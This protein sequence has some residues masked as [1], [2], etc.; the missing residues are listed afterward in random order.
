MRKTLRLLL[1]SSLIAALALSPLA[2]ASGVGYSELVS[3]CG[4]RAQRSCND[5]FG[6]GCTASKC[7]D[8]IADVIAGKKSQVEYEKHCENDCSGQLSAYAQLKEKWLRHLQTYNPCTDDFP[9]L[10]EP[11]SPEGC[12]SS[13]FVTYEELLQLRCQIVSKRQ[14][15][16]C[17][18]PPA[19]PVPETDF[20]L[21]AY[22]ERRFCWYE[23]E[24][25][26]SAYECRQQSAG[27]PGMGASCAASAAEAARESGC[28]L[29]PSLNSVALKQ[30]IKTRTNDDAARVL[31]IEP[32]RPTDSF[33][34]LDQIA[35]DIHGGTFRTHRTRQW[36]TLPQSVNPGAQVRDETGVF[37]WYEA[38]GNYF[39]QVIS[40][41]GTT[42][43]IEAVE[44][45]NPSLL[46]ASDQCGTTE[47]RELLNHDWR[48]IERMLSQ[49]A[50][51]WLPL[52]KSD[53]K[54]LGDRISQSRCYRGSDQQIACYDLLRFKELPNVTESVAN[55]FAWN[56]NRRDW[57]EEDIPEE[58]E[59]TLLSTLLKHDGQATPFYVLAQSNGGSPAAIT[60]SPFPGP[61]IAFKGWS[62][63]DD[64]PWVP[65]SLG[66]VLQSEL[67]DRLG[68]PEYQTD[69]LARQWIER[70]MS[71][72]D[73]RLLR[74]DDDGECWISKDKLRCIS[75]N[76]GES[77]ILSE[78]QY[79][80]PWPS[81]DVGHVYESLESDDVDGKFVNDI[82][83]H[84]LT[85]EQ[86]PTWLAL[87]SDRTLGGG[88]ILSSEETDFDDGRCRRPLEYWS[89]PLLK[90]THTINVIVPA[91]ER[92][93]C[94]G[95][96]ADRFATLFDLL[97]Y[98]A[99]DL[100]GHTGVT[101]YLYSDQ[102]IVLLQSERGDQPVLRLLELTQEAGESLQRCDTGPVQLTALSRF[103]ASQ[104]EEARDYQ[105][106]PELQ[107]LA[108]CLLSG[109]DH[110]FGVDQSSLFI[111]RNFAAKQ[112]TTLS[113]GD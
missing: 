20:N 19:C 31:Q 88:F 58:R 91:T 109:S 37:V 94:A 87:S 47:P 103:L 39:T 96:L 99:Q 17:P 75:A 25:Q 59:N 44:W 107:D 4:I 6:S 66:S 67:R 110:C 83:N 86:P 80:L 18:N 92:T 50:S 82:I 12:P 35:L 90:T 62:G 89:G 85:L 34:L 48:D 29:I 61:N 104:H 3:Q 26:Y 105:Y 112:C 102:P 69:S 8:L 52:E 101:A 28:S 76:W 108:Q 10:A 81:E 49:G 41:D 79:W 16:K 45:P 78:A 106:L 77:K 14:S 36:E 22:P 113:S 51:G 5:R 64:G 97:Q 63:S 30:L 70:K 60:I 56:P 24:N 42:G 1:P 72:P 9:E 53:V 13:V 74:T 43:D 46:F 111:V 95:N 54:D 2:Q 33:S 57:F 27:E 23:D 38:S 65:W 7:R 93:L 100:N 11:P 21:V 71:A 55:I 68:E 84:S 73:L 32:W 40:A 15:T 98:A